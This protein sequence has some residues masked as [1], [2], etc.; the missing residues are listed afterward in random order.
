MGDERYEPDTLR[1][2]F[3]R[4]RE[5]SFGEDEGWVLSAEEWDMGLRHAA[6]WAADRKRLERLTEAICEELCDCGSFGYPAEDEHEDCV[7]R[8]F[9]AALAPNAARDATGDTSPR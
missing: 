5:E 3:L 8:N 7:Y 9:M 1:A 6:T 2:L 4:W